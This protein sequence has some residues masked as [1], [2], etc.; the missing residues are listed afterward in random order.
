MGYG[1]VIQAEMHYS[2]PDACVELTGTTQ[3]LQETR[4]FLVQQLESRVK[5]ESRYLANAS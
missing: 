3:S 2:I 5:N 4:S 1:H